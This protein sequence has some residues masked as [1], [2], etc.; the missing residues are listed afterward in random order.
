MLIRV[1]RLGIALEYFGIL[2]NENNK[3]IY[4]YISSGEGTE[5]MIYDSRK[6]C[7]IKI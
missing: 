6:C 4:K 7:N 5:Y 1:T 2:I 3:E